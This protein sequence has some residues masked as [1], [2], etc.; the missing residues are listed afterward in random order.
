MKVSMVLIAMYVVLFTIVSQKGYQVTDTV[1]GTTSVKLKGSGAIGDING[2]I[3]D[4]LVVDA[5]DLVQPSFEQNAFF[6]V[7]ARYFVDSIDSF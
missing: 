2:P 5:M 7:T 1:S 6:L 4:L 3:N